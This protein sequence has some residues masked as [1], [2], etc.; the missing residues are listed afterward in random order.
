MP[1]KYEVGARSVYSTA[2]A[3]KV[4][5][6]TEKIMHLAG[7]HWQKCGQL[8]EADIEF[9]TATPALFG[10]AEFVPALEQYVDRYKVDLNLRSTPLR[11]MAVQ[12]Q[13]VLNRAMVK[14]L[15]NLILFMSCPLK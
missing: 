9:P 5:W 12:R 4:C 3:H 7:H 2:N 6:R 10:V 14:L 8:K 15:N 11:W 13:H 1:A